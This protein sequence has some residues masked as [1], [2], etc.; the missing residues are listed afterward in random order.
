MDTGDGSP[1]I[2]LSYFGGFPCTFKI[3]P[4]Y[5]LHL[6]ICTFNML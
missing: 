6:F 4:A 5:I 2:Q 1:R 3:F